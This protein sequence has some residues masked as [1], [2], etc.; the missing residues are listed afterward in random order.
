M[1]AVRRRNKVE[2]AGLPA[3]KVAG[4]GDSTPLY[5][6]RFEAVDGLIRCSALSAGAF[7]P[8][9]CKFDRLASTSANAHA[10]GIHHDHSSY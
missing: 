2:V 5:Y 8:G 9:S 10:P 6:S 1:F 4:L 3:D 7:P